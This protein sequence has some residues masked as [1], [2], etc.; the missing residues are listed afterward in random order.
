[1]T[2]NHYFAGFVSLS[3][4]VRSIELLLFVPTSKFHLPTKGLNRDY[5]E[6]LFTSKLKQ[7]HRPTKAN[8][9]CGNSRYM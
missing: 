9:Q 7:L 3:T 5:E 8:C 1:M 2:S 4:Y 6:F